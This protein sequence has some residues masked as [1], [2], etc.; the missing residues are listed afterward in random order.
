MSEQ[1][2]I[3]DLFR[4]RHF[5]RD[6]IILCVRWYLR[7]KLSLR[8]LVEM[9]YERG[10]HLAHTTDLR[11]V[12]QY[13]GPDSNNSVKPAG[14]RRTRSPKHS[15]KL[16]TPLK[17][18]WR[19]KCKAPIDAD[20]FVVRSAFSGSCSETGSWDRPL[21]VTGPFV[22]TSVIHLPGW[23]GQIVFLS[24]Q[25]CPASPIQD[26][27][28]FAARKVSALP[29]NR[30]LTS[31]MMTGFSAVP[32]ILIGIPVASEGFAAFDEL[33][34]FAS[35][36]TPT[37]GGAWSSELLRAEGDC[38]RHVR[39]SAGLVCAVVRADWSAYRFGSITLAIVILIPRAGPPWWVAFSGL[40]KFRSELGR[41]FFSIVWPEGDAQPSK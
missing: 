3:E 22:Q 26:V 34:N 28:A 27:G 40:L 32:V 12:D 4:G 5:D 33:F 24:E 9:M 35:R 17:S 14:H 29:F 6:L 23:L 15:P 30:P 36:L 41:V 16:I 20:Q 18:A 39:V 1:N 2:R 13:A 8:D 19:L 31:A 25:F 38:V 11:T 37:G 7:Y 10:L 21:Q